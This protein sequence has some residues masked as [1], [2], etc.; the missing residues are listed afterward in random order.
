VPP[1]TIP[2]AHGAGMAR[3]GKTFYT[4]NI[5]GGGVSGLVAI[6]TDTNVVLGATDTGNPP[7]P[8]PHNIALTPDGKKLYVTHSGAMAN[9]VTVYTATRKN[10]MPVFSQTVTVGLNPFG[11]VYVP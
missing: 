3:N 4:T 9:Q 8:T 11:I 10:L 6:D 7:I 5:S 2:G 1:L